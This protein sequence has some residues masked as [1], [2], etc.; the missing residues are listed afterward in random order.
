VIRIPFAFPILFDRGGVLAVNKPEGLAAIPER[1]K[2]R[3]SLLSLL[4]LSMPEKLYVVHRLDK[5]VSGV[6][7]F[8]KTPAAHKCLNDQFASRRIAKT[9]LALLHGAM[10]EE[11]G[12]IDKPVRE[13]GSGR[14]GVD[15]KRGKASATSYEVVRRMEHYTLVRVRTSTGRRHQIRVHFYSVDHPVVG[16]RRYG[17]KALQ[18]R[19][20]RLM[21]HAATISFELPTGETVAVEA[22]VPDTFTTVL[23][24]AGR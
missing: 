13:F 17:E 23:D 4:Q 14:M 19:F 11:A 5:D 3:E 8:A 24:A 15:A 18:E 20:P 7:L 12:T 2:E 22:S 9:Y 16:D 1:E 6:M 21:L 10:P